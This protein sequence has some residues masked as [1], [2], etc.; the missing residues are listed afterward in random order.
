MIFFKG[1]SPSP[2]KQKKV[3]LPEAPKPLPP[4][5]PPTEMRTD[6]NQVTKDAYTREAKKKGIGA[7]LLAG[8]TGG[9]DASGKRTLLG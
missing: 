9:V 3:K 1:G 4:P 5:P 8:E 7:T 2:P 6:T